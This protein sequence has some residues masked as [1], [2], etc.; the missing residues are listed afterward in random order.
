MRALLI[1][2][3][4]AGRGARKRLKKLRRLLEEEGL[5]LEVAV[6]ED[7]GSA[8]RSASS[9]GFERVLAA[10]GDGT[11]RAA[12]CSTD[13]PVGIIPLGTSNSI[14]RSLEVPLS[15][16]KA[17]RVAAR[18][19]V[20]ALDV[21]ELNGRPFLLCASAG[22]D[23]EIMRRLHRARRGPTSIP[24]YLSFAMSAARSYR[25]RSIRLTPEGGAPMR[26]QLVVAANMRRYGGFFMAAPEADPA[27]GLLDFVV[28]RGEGARG[29]L[30]C[31]VYAH[32]GRLGNLRR[33]R[34]M[35]APGGRLE[36]PGPVPVPV[37]ADG[38]P[39]GFLPAEVGLRPRAVRIVCPAAS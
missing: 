22:L 4:S 18:G 16:K 13:L 31:A 37:Q 29:L 19:K 32:A 24:E 23:A 27:D 20:R 14:A 36:G 9:A 26:G 6:T 33:A 5:A 35:K 15:L 2:N 3:P 8:A 11:V 12:A 25:G 38:E 1:V 34:F 28:I 7:A 39:A 10:G 17:V 30:A 21:G